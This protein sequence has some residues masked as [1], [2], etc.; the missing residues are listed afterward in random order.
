VVVADPNA[1][2]GGHVKLL[3]KKVLS[4]WKRI[5]V[6][7]FSAGGVSAE[8]VVEKRGNDVVAVALGDAVLG[9]RVPKRMKRPAFCTY[10]KASKLPLGE[11]E[12]V[13]RG[14]VNTVSAGTS[15][16]D[17]VMSTARDHILGFIFDAIRD[18]SKA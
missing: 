13:K 14:G 7:G 12:S 15:D 1:S 11:R 18:D 10:W 6:I 9:A 4:K 8:K 3:L 17:M 2:R 16:H 5:A